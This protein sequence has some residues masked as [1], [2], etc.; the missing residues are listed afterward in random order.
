MARVTI[1]VKK[2]DANYSY[3]AGRKTTYDF[4]AEHDTRNNSNFAQLAYTLLNEQLSDIHSELRGRERR[5][6]LRRALKKI[7]VDLRFKNV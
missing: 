3:A 5:L 4:L 1:D 2:W 7:N 6:A